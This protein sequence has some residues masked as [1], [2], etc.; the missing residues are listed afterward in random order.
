MEWQRTNPGRGAKPF[1]F[2]LC[3][4][5]LRLGIVSLGAGTSNAGASIHTRLIVKV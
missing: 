4:S 2:T 1:D 5:R 3:V